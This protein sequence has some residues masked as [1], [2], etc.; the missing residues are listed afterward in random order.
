LTEGA[1]LSD[2]NLKAQKYNFG[3][4]GQEDF[5]F[6]QALRLYFRL[7]HYV[8]ASKMKYPLALLI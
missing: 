1:N 5:G 4:L 8:I 7:F 6:K 3:S 2:E